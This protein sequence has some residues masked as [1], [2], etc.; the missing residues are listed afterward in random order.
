VLCVPLSVEEQ[1]TFGALLVAL[2]Y[3]GDDLLLAAFV[4]AKSPSTEEQMALPTFVV[5]A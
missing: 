3:W 2:C 5:F 4:Q 1:P